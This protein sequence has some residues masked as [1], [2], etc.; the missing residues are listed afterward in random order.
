MGRQRY[1]NARELTIT[2]DCGGSNGAAVRLWK[3]ELQKLA[4][5]IGLVIRVHHYPP[6]TSKWRVDRR[7][8]NRDRSESRES[9]AL[10]GP[11][12]AAM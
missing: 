10:F 6:G 5:E 3:F 4:D 7:H 12:K 1:P 2:A 11:A 9:A 8:D